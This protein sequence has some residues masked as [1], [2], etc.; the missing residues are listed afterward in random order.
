MINLIETLMIDDIKNGKIDLKKD[1]TMNKEF[2]Y[3]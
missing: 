3:A 1:F 2:G